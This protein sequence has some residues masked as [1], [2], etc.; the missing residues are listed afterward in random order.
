MFRFFEALFSKN[1][2]ASI[3]PIQQP[4]LVPPTAPDFVAL[5][6]ETANSDRASICQI[7]IAQFRNSAVVDEWK[8]Y[9]DPQDHFD[10]GFVA[11]HGITEATVKGAP[12]FD[13][14]VDKIQRI[15]GGN[16]VVT[17][18]EF[19]RDAL[20]Q[21]ADKYGLPQFNCAWLD[22]ASVARRTWKEI[23]IRGYG[24]AEVCKIV[25]YKFHHHDA[26]E[27]AKAAGQ[28]MLA[29]I[30]KSGLDLDGW[31][32]KVL[33]PLF[34]NDSDCF[35]NYF[36]TPPSYARRIAR[37]GAAKGKL[38]GEVLVFTGELTIPRREAANRAAEIG[39]EVANSVNQ[40]TTILVM[41]ESLLSDNQKS[42]KQ[43]KAETLI[44]K[45]QNIR[46]MQ[47]SDF[48]QLVNY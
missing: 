10:K 41:G 46:I 31:Q 48:R 35:E 13:A 28:I 40:R 39:C 18:T 20:N 14:L 29:A 47:E 5:D 19:D 22:S 26:L 21:A 23:S 33:E 1:T 16:I 12:R 25:G 3:A 4:C 36:S 44:A 17:H 24:L 2:R 11:I 6:V 7:G 43:R 30:N 9:V 45:G 8:T 34:G 42:Y 32:T 15:I 38:A 27:D 37:H